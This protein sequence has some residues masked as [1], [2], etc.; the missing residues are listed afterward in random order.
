MKILV[1]EGLDW[2]TIFSS[3]NFWP[4]WFTALIQTGLV[5]IDP[6][7]AVVLFVSLFPAENTGINPIKLFFC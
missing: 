1:L 7:S 6:L 5:G 3:V 4:E 2:S